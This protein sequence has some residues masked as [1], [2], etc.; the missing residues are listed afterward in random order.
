[1]IVSMLREKLRS[2]VMRRRSASISLSWMSGVP[3]LRNSTPGMLGY[4]PASVFEARDGRAPATTDKF[5]GLGEQRSEV[6]DE[7]RGSE[8][9]IPTH[10]D[11]LRHVRMPLRRAF[12]T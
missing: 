2:S 11:R 5:V 6:T 8:Q 10:A 7:R 1:M 4:E 3:R 9:R 12:C